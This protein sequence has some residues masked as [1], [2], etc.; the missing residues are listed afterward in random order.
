MD[1]TPP[2]LQP[3]RN[4]DMV[5]LFGGFTMLFTLVYVLDRYGT[6]YPLELVILAVAFVSYL[7]LSSLSP[8]IWLKIRYFDWFITVPLLVYVV[9]QYGSRP[10]WLL[11]SPVILMLGAG[12]MGVLGPG[13]NY[14]SWIN[15]G[16]L[17]YFVFFI[18]LVTS[19]NT[20]PWPLIWIFF[21]SWALYG[22]VDRLE[23]PRDHWAYTVLDIFNK[24]IFIIFL[25]L[26]IA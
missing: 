25:L 7:T 8:N 4:I 19:N 20:L 5:H 17:F 24:P 16:F 10:Y 23:G 2:L 13:K 14:Q 6:D 11:V 1:T 15:W 3:S 26:A 9:S 12:F 21:G 18:L 22:F